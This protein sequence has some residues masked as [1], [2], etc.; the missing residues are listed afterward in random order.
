MTTRFSVSAL[1]LGTLLLTLI[2]LI[3]GISMGWHSPVVT[4]DHQSVDL[5]FE[6]DADDAQKSTTANG[7]NSSHLLSFRRLTISSDSNAGRPA[8][9]SLDLLEIMRH[10]D[11]QT[12]APLFPGISTCPASMMLAL[13][14]LINEPLDEH[15]NRML[16]IAA[17]SGNQFAI[18]SLMQLGADASLLNSGQQTPLMA[19]RCSDQTTRDAIIACLTRQDSTIA[20]VSP[21]RG[22]SRVAS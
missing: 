20:A 4:H 13:I 22:L 5:R 2:C 14:P 17:R 6:G 3:T 15:G 7:G 16:H 21:P 18:W 11:Q 1:A 12:L 19:L 9:V 8:M 10:Y